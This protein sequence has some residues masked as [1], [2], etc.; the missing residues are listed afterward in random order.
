MRAA[1]IRITLDASPALN[2]I[3]R[4]EGPRAVTAKLRLIPVLRLNRGMFAYDPSLTLY[5]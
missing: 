5:L 1:L 3:R 4:R 2:A